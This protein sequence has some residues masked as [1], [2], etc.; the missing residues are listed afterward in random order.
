M[1]ASASPDWLAVHQHEKKQ[2]KGNP[3]W[4]RGMKS[5]NP[6]G[7]PRGISNARAKLNQRLLSDT[8]GIVDKM[9]AQALDGDAQSASLILSRVMPT[10]RAQVERVEFDFDSSAPLAQQVQSVLQAIAGGEVSADIG[11]Q[12]IEAIGALG[13]IKQIDELEDRISRLEGKT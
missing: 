5:P 4:K 2:Q 7:R 3:N 11:K 1:D 6:S 8:Q 10:L 12:I 13:A 9:V